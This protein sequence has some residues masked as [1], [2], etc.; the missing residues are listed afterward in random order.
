[1]LHHSD[2][3]TFQLKQSGKIRSEGRVLVW[4]SDIQLN[5]LFNSPKLHMD[6]THSARHP[7]NSNRYSLYKHFFMAHVS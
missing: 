3:P 7:I 4:S 6:G 1:L 2:D 5:L